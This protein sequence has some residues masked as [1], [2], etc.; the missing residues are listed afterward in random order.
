[1]LLILAILLAIAIP[2]FLGVTKSA[3]DRAVQSNLNTAETNAKAVFQ[4]NSQS[5]SGVTTTMLSSAEPSLNWTTTGSSASGTISVAT[6]ALDG[7]GIV[8]S[9]LSSAGNCWLIVDNTSTVSNATG[10]AP[11]TGT[12]PTAATTVPATSLTSIVVPPTAGLFYL[13]IKGSAKAV[14][15]N[16]SAPSIPVG[17]TYSYK[18]SGGFPS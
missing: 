7:N 6:S 8:L 5:Y 3:N 4:T 15:C 1:V 9:S 16:A 18:A 12:A 10:N 17:G 13:E 11:W 14:N 2:T